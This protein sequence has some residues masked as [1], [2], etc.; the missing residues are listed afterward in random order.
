[1]HYDNR[2]PGSRPTDR[3]IH[4]IAPYVDNHSL[5]AIRLFVII[6]VV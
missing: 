5:S 3:D 1:M 6:S 2:L 4:P